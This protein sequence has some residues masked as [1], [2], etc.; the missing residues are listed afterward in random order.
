[1]PPIAPTLPASDEDRRFR[2]V[3]AGYARYGGGRVDERLRELRDRGALSIDD[4]DIDMLQRIAN[5]ETG[6]CI[7]SINSYDDSFMSMGIMQ[8]T[9]KHTD[10]YFPDGKLQ[11]LIARAPH[12]FRRYGIELDPPRR[13]RLPVPNGKGA[14]YRPVAIKGTARAGDLRGLAWAKR[15]WVAG[16]DPDVIAAY[17]QLAVEVLEE[18]RRRIEKTVGGAFLPHYRRSPAL[19]ALIQETYNHRPRWLYVALAK[20]TEAAKGREVDTERFLEL[21]RAAI[22]EVYAK[23]GK[24]ESATNLIVKTATPVL[25]GQRCPPTRRPGRS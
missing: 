15:F 18:S 20:A 16:L 13:Y 3:K 12:A 22:R 19:R 2:R 9:V 24:P 21:V 4:A 1:M 5:V 17:A 10:S 14:A 6:G 8:W 25:R 11:R 23:H 7:Q